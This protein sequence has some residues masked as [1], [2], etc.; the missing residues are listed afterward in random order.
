MKLKPY[1]SIII[2]SRNDDHQGDMFKHMQTAITS[3]IIQVKRYNLK[4]ELILVEWNPPVDR[5][6]LKDALS[7]PDDLGP[8]AI[9]I[10]VIPPSIH[11]KY[12]CSNKAKIV[13]RAASNVG[14][15]RA[16]G[17]F[18]L[19]TNADILFSD[20][21]I[22]FLSLEKLNKNSIYRANRCDVHRDVLKCSSVQEQIDFCKKNIIRVWQKPDK[23]P[24][25]LI[26]YPI[27]HSNACDFIL[28]A[29]KYWHLLH[30]YPELNNLGIGTDPLLCYM[31]Y[32]AGLKEKILKDPMRVYH[33]DHKSKWREPTKINFFKVK[34]FYFLKNKINNLFGNDSIWLVLIKRIYRF[35]KKISQF[36]INLFYSLF[37]PF[38]KKLA[39]PGAWDFNVA[40]LCVE[41]KKVLMGMLRKK[42]SYIYNDKNWG[43]PQE[44]FTEYVIFSKRKIIKK[45][46]DKKSR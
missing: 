7:W 22:N 11:K 16:R 19:A 18:I 31:A 30:G 25:G 37:G 41:Y 13:I 45:H 20:E 29:R 10:I 21:L 3:L 2:F 32:L 12:K 40:Y 14:I 39:P 5:P 6:L 23:S 33:I 42:R 24:H 38:F 1:L 28:F 26:K 9:R 35:K 17:E 36:F 4:A 44:N 34:I 27:L 46:Y 15:R 8:L 43:L